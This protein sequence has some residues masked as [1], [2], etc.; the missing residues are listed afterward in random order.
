MKRRIIALIGGMAVL[1]A[2]IFIVF[3]PRGRTGGTGSINLTVLDGRTD[4]PLP[5]AVV[6]IPETGRTYKLD[7]KARTGRIE[8]PAAPDAR[9][10]DIHQKPW[11]EITVL[12]YCNGYYPLALFYLAVPEGAERDGPTLY[13]FPD[14]GS[15][16]EPFSLVEGPDASWVRELLAKYAP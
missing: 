14:D 12:V 10:S 15:M 3:A 13:L 1:A 2:L 8:V 16:H 9:F 4:E 5:H 6:V 7:K 11:G